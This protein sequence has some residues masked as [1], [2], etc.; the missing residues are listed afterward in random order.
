MPGL[1]PPE[2]VADRRAMARI[3]GAVKANPCAHCVNRDREVMAWGRSVCRADGRDFPKCA[4]DGREPK[5]ILD[6][7]TLR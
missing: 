5:F 6:E 1:S 7:V 2:H 4:L 3:A